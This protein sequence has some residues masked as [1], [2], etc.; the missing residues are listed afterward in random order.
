MYCNKC[1]AE[2]A[3]N[4]QFCSNCGQIIE[5]PVKNKTAASTYKGPLG[6]PTPVLVW[7]ILGLAFA[8]TLFLS[9]L[10]I[11]FSAIGLGK[12]RSFMEFCGAGSKQATIGRNL[13]RA[14][15]I[16]GIIFTV[17]LVLFIIL[18]ASG[19]IDFF[20]SK[21]RYYYYYY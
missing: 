12:A 15:L 6:N 3:E 5:S 19:E 14:G 13:A 21:P 2:I 16:V 10:G 20:T 11:I 17:F 18:I 7:G 4:S 8:C 1:G 9:F